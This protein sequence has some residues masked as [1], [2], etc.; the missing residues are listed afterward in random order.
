MVRLP[1]R[2]SETPC[3][4]CKVAKSNTATVDFTPIEARFRPFAWTGNGRQVRW[5]RTGL[6]HQRTDLPIVETKWSMA[7]DKT[8]HFRQGKP[9][10]ATAF[11]H[12]EKVFVY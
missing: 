8:F 10:R 3:N 7:S 6:R 5:M 9:M 12:D 2:G 4:P 11:A 1:S